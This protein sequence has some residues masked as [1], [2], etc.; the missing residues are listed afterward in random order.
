MKKKFLLFLI[1]LSIL[2]VGN[3][4]KTTNEFQ[5]HGKPLAKL[6]TNYHT[7]FKDSKSLSQFQLKRAYFGYAYKFSHNWSAKVLLDVGDPGVGK[8]KETAYLKNAY[9]KYKKD[10]LTVSFG[11]IGTTQFKTSEKIWGN[12]Y[13]FKSFQDANKFNSS[14]DLGVNLDYKFA[15]FISADF[16]ITNGEG[17]KQIQKDSVFRYAIGTTI[18]PVE[19]VTARFYA[20]ITG[21]KTKQESFSA[22]LS[23]NNKQLMVATE[24]NFQK[25]HKLVEGGDMYG[26]SIFSS[27]KTGKKLK[28]FAR[29]DILKSANL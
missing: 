29:F 28:L 26:A 12:R 19:N 9:F 3:A 18:K 2:G 1:M 8:F 14:A 6:F 15:E 27:F 21:E 5:P 13:I 17:Y 22:F 25:N 24:Y 7:T 10:H 4:Q 20:D 23:Y 11:L 16:T